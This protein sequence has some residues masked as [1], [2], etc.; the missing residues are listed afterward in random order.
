MFITAVFLFVTNLQLFGCPWQLDRVPQDV[1]HRGWF[2]KVWI[3][4]D[5]RV[6]SKPKITYAVWCDPHCESRW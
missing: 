5:M 3:N 2:T 4:V 1:H 6:Y